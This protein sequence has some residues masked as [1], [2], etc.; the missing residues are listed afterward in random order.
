MN[1]TL[2]CK[3][4]KHSFRQWSDWW[5]P[6]SVTMRC[7]LKY[8][9]ARTTVDPVT[10]PKHEEAYYERCSISRMTWSS[11]PENCG[12]H[13]QYWQPKNKKGLFKLIAKEHG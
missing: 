5:L 12:E 1:E 9:E 8:V 6:S 3:D 13:G 7:R 4:C 11:K 2:L 10:G